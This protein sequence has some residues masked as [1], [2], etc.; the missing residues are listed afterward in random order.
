M[1]KLN[2]ENIFEINIETIY[3]LIS[4]QVNFGK[5]EVTEEMRIRSWGTE[6]RAS[7]RELM[8][9]HKTTNAYRIFNQAR[10]REKGYKIS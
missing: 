7:G 10:L 2:P 4:L 3:R 8:K 6:K 9:Y 1:A 5:K